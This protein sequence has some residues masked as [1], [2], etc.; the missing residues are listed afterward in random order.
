MKVLVFA[1][2]PPPY[3]GQSF[4]VQQLL[5]HVG[6]IGPSSPHPNEIVFYHV[7][8]RLSRQVDDIG[9]WRVE[10]IRLLLGYVLK[11]WY[12]RWK[13]ALEVFYYVPAPAKAS[14]LARDWVVL[15]LVASLFQFR[16][17][18]WHAG[19]LGAWVTEAL[20]SPKR[21]TRMAAWITCRIFGK[22]ELSVVLNNY[23]RH[24]VEIFAPQRIEVI[25]NGVAD[26]CP[27]FAETVLPNRLARWQMRASHPVGSPPPPFE[28]L[29][30]AH[31][32]RSK[33]LFDSL[34]AVAFANA[35]SKETNSPETF[36]LTV[37]GAFGSHEEEVEFHRR[38]QQK[39]LLLPTTSDKPA[40]AVIYAGYVEQAEKDRLLRETDA[41]CFASFFANEVQPVS[42]LEALA[43]GMPVVLSR[44]HDLPAMVPSELA[45][46]TEINNPIA[47]ADQFPLLTQENRFEDYRRCYVERYSL[48]FHCQRMQECLLLGARAS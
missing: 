30:L 36:R 5:S 35:R 15:T 22:H 20:R 6:K 34:D 4:M 16:V 10:K 38:I 48:T 23:S 46:L 25:E 17:Y 39:D 43:Y 26:P 41:L 3:H 14:A 21:L 27:D 19:G 32:T 33:G 44:W 18:H 47:L 9:V 7:N 2:T 12:L 40:C 37:A 42:V 45:H 11:A 13:Y 29:F 1:H 28:L 8:A 24:E 31:A